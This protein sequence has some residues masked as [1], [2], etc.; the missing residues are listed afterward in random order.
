M[1]F[2]ESSMVGE[3]A[4]IPS[5]EATVP[6]ATTAA[7]FLVNMLELLVLGCMYSQHYN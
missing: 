5:G 2:T 4:A 6:K 3:A 1:A 7:I